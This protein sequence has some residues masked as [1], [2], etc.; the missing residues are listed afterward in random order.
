M[1]SF[2]LRR[3]RYFV[4]VAERGSVTRAARHL[5][6][7]QPAL[8]QHIKQLEEEVGGALFRRSARGVDLTV[9]GEKLLAHARSILNEI[10]ALLQDLRQAPSEPQGRVVIG[11]APT[12]GHVLAG[13]ILEA[14]SAT[15]PHVRV[16]IRETMSRD[17]PDLILGGAIDYALTYDIAARR[18][19]ASS[20]VF[21]EDS[22][23]VG[24]W[25]KAKAL[26]LQRTK[27]LAFDT[28]R[29]IPL[30]LSGPANAFRGK[31]EQTALARRF[32]LDI[33]A[34]VDS[35]TIRRDLA[36]RGVAFT[37]LSGTAIDVRP[38]DPDVYAARIVRPRIQRQ[39]CFVRP[40][41]WSPS[42][43]AREVL[44]LV[45]HTLRGVLGNAAWAGATRL[46]RRSLLDP[47]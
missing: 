46:R 7:A 2:D 45:D 27:D 34:E 20:P 9:L 30:F 6:I 32:A 33:G 13:S 31:L 18:G 21:L 43:A 19:M 22:F 4:A 47:A 14:V 44:Q 37:V 1:S 42:R 40:E 29:G 25:A 35:L 11:M 15:L 24:S 17:V 26:K 41:R 16:Q 3:L 28:L 8:S 38:G 36:L 10:D 23:V 12:I 5:Y 39:I